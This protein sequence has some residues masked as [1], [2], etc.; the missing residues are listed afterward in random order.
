MLVDGHGRVVD[1]VRLAVTDKCNLRCFYCMPEEGIDFV[2]RKELLTYEELTRVVGLLSE[3]GVSKVRI[4]GGEPFLRKGIMT[5]FHSLAELPLINNISVT[6]NGTLTGEYLDELISL[7]IKSFNLSI[8]SIDRQR[9]AEI[10]RRDSFEKVWS[11]YES[12]LEKDL[13]LKLNCVVMK[14]RNIQDLIAM[15][16]LGKDANVSVRFIEEMPFNGDGSFYKKLEWDYTKILEHLTD[17]FGQVEKLPDPQGS[18]SLNYRVPSFRGS[19]GII[20]A[21]TRSFCGSCNRLRITPDGTIKTCLYD[22]GV[23]N[24]RDIM[25]AG[26][27]DEEV[28][29][30]VKE[31]I[32]HKAKDGF[33]AEKNRSK[34]NGVSES[35]ATIGG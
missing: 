6:T 1:Y 7:G 13:N 17:H 32:S 27:T 11:C 29:L 24:I 34:M 10:T 12:M 33:Q 28:M 18:T 9:F 25:R 14:D 23:F 21:Y 30:A 2:Q 20:P 4:T 19:F 15:V 16:D 8:D 3:E 31:A 22:D 26:A 35:M 5:F